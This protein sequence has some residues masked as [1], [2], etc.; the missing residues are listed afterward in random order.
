[1]D[2][3]R[4]GDVDLALTG[5]AREGMPLVWRNQLA[6]AVARRSLAIAVVDTIGRATRA[7]AEVRVYAAGTKRL[8]G[9]RLIDT[10]SGY[11]SQSELPVHVGVP[12]GVASV[13]VE[14]IVPLNGRRETKL[15]RGVNPAAY[16]GRTLVVRR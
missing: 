15:T 6:G 10:G 4:D 14:V 9:M 8:L 16:A 1:M 12:A 11:N 3:D 13:D 5:S 2:I 7:G